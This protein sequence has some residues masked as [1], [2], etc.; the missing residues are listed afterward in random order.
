MRGELDALSDRKLFRLS[1]GNAS[2]LRDDD[3]DLEKPLQTLI[4]NNLDSLVGIRF[5]ASEYSI[6]KTHAGRIDSLGLDEN[7]CHVMLE[8]KRSVTENVIIRGYYLN[9]LMNHQDE[10]IS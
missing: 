3:S 10:L 7:S 4:E 9:W 8:Y 2:E 1:N 6:G 5:L